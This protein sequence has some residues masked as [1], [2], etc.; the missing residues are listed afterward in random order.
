MS[1][2]IVSSPAQP[3][4][5]QSGQWRIVSTPGPQSFDVPWW[6]SGLRGAAGGALFNFD[7]ELAGAIG[8]RAFGD[9]W[10]QRNEMARAEHPGWYTGGQIGGALGL[11][12]ATG[13]AGGLFRGA[14]G[15]GEAGVTAANAAN[16]A[17]QAGR[18]GQV[19]RMIGQPLGWAARTAGAGAA[20]GAASR[21]GE[22]D[23]D[24]QQRAAQALTPGNAATDATLALGFGAVAAPVART[25]SGAVGAATRAGE[26][27]L[28]NWRARGAYDTALRDAQAAL[29]RG[30]SVASLT[31][32][33]TVLSRMRRAAEDQMSN[34]ETRGAAAGQGAALQQLARDVFGIE[35]TQSQASNSA[36]LR[37]WLADAH[38]NMFGPVAKQKA[39]EILGAQ[40]DQTA[41]AFMRIGSRDVV[42]PAN[43]AEG[44]NNFRTHLIAAHDADRAAARQA[45]EEL[46]VFGPVEVS[47]GAVRPIGLET[48]RGPLTEEAS[49][50]GLT[51]RQAPP[52]LDEA[53]LA[54]MNTAQRRA[55]VD[56]ARA[57]RESE[58][59]RRAF[60]TAAAF[61][62]DIIGRMNHLIELRRIHPNAAYTFDELRSLKQRANEMWADAQAG[63]P[64][65]RVTPSDFQRVTRLYGRVADWF[66]SIGRRANE[67]NAPLW[68]A[69]AHDGTVNPGST[70]IF[71]PG[72]EGVRNAIRGRMGDPNAPLPDDL[73][74]ELARRFGIVNGKWRDYY[75]LYGESRPGGVRAASGPA[76]TEDNAVTR[77]VS[78]IIGPT[79]TGDQALRAL[80]G[81]TGIHP[82]DGAH[83]A[84]RAIKEKFGEDSAEWRGLQQSILA[85]F[86]DLL[87]LAARQDNPRALNTIHNQLSNLLSKRQDFVREAFDEPQQIM[88]HQLR[89]VLQRMQGPGPSM[90]NPSNT[91]AT[92]LRFAHRLPLTKW[93]MDAY[94][95]G[96]SVP[97]QAIRE[98]T[99]AGPPPVLNAK[100]LRALGWGWMFGPNTPGGQAAWGLANVAGARAIPQAQD[101]Q[102]YWDEQYGNGY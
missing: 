74:A 94:R 18:L 66:E 39:D 97:N 101:D 61:H 29:A 62:D 12:A 32:P 45:E 100:A 81:D 38:S 2:T 44:G 93:L 60:P 40:L 33:G 75:Q 48:L 36:E 73:G 6:E 11:A 21:L 85:R 50:I 64:G 17:Q 55:Y 69:G 82:Q 96:V 91:A 51:P 49:A 9:E 30:E 13:G 43:A 14:L 42:P 92:L 53:A 65:G 95:D 63:V 4:P 70:S 8:G 22:A 72:D 84:L 86:S 19:A 37:H 28:E 31:A 71:R 98:L 56:A 67:G 46:S 89:E 41:E 76:G 57:A 26:H 27:V 68:P 52:P 10:R 47:S 25:L 54:S 15:L 5:T 88:L 79:T 23:G 77:I 3:Q 34:F 102:A 87:R 59:A 20:Y 78:K 16:A 90:S 58:N 83:L 1:W 99:T 24:L 7:D 80:I 35:L